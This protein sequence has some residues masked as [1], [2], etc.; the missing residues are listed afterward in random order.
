[1]LWRGEGHELIGKVRTM[2]ALARLLRRDRRG[3]ARAREWLVSSHTQP[4][5]S[6]KDS[7]PIQLVVGLD[8]GTSFTKVV[9]GESRIRYAVPFGPFCNGGNPVFL[10]SG[11]SVLAESDE[12]RLGVEA[13]GGILHDNLKM[14]LIERDFSGDVRARAAAFLALVLRYARGWLLEKHGRVYRGRKIEW[15]VN[16]GLPTD[17][18]DDAEL[19]SAYVSIVDA[20][21]RMSIQ[22]GAISLSCAKDQP[23]TNPAEAG[24]LPE[25]YVER[26]L[27]ADRINAFPEFSAQ[28]AGYVR[29]PRRQDGLHTMVDVGG[30]TLD[31]TVFNVHK[32][33]YGDDIFPIFARRVRPLGT[34]YL[35]QARRNALR[36]G[37]EWSY[38]PF[39]ALPSDVKFGQAHDVSSDDLK[40]LDRPFRK[41][42]HTTVAGAL[43]YTKEYRYPS[44]PHW[45]STK[46]GY[47]TGMPSFFCGGGASA[48]FYE[49]LLK[50]FEV[51][52]PPYKLSQSILPI[53]DDL[54]VPRTARKSNARLAVAYGLSF[55]PYDIGRI[56]RMSEIAD[57]NPDPTPPNYRD[58]YVGK[59]LT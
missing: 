34:R 24:E 12:C 10:P 49:T 40:E 7:Q 56:I 23:T 53:P 48:D 2:R 16:V 39:D 55:D 21:W 52:Q 15:F 28:V 45:D 27:P 8:F 25:E 33:S 37:G 19:T 47:G 41:S 17:S 18:F 30:G 32:D 54:N 22:P 50:G 42:A 59:E 38:S 26:L 11:L 36:G 5:V 9:I 31:V 29:S 4:K 14:P 3:S 43:K 57:V 46:R 1:M 51:L 20:A 13:H 6:Q 35:M 44:A 58:R